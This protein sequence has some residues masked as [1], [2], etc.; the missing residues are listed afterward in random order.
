[1]AFLTSEEQD[2]V[3]QR[4][5][6]D[7][8][9]AQGDVSYSA[10]EDL[11]V[12]RQIRDTVGKEFDAELAKNGE[13]VVDVEAD[14]DMEGTPSTVA[15]PPEKTVDCDTLDEHKNNV[16]EMEVEAEAM[17]AANVCKHDPTGGCVLPNK[18]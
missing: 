16:G 11:Q 14:E 5:G 13:M 8:I 1:M 17:S 6:E 7:D 4:R 10:L 15:C 18:A 12:N 2:A 3:L 9:E